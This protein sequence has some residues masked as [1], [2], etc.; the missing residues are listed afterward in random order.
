MTSGPRLRSGSAIVMVMV[1][2]AIVGVIAIV[3]SGQA[4]FVRRASVRSHYGFEAVEICE[5]AINEAHNQVVFEDIFPSPPFSNLQDWGVKIATND[6]NIGA[7]YP[8][9]T[10]NFRPLLDSTTKAPTGGQLF[11]SMLW[12]ADKRPTKANNYQGFLK[13]YNTPS[14]S[15][16]GAAMAGFKS[17]TPVKMSVLSW[18]RDFPEGGK[19]WQD[20]GV[21]HYET[22]C[23][24]DDG[25]SSITRTMS[26]D[27]MFTLYA[28]TI[29]LRPDTIDGVPV[30]PDPEAAE[31]DP[32]KIFFHFI[33]S[34]SNL[35][36]VII[37]S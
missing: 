35:K 18:R 31:T 25:K 33:K 28:H 3:T 17:L 7:G 10:F 14:T 1:F 5:S 29:A 11:V 8:G 19:A 22:A 26:V 13:I 36:T 2:L 16:N 12:P 32:L 6:T 15:A 20:W 24:F 4:S 21:L 37:R 9:Y 30:S 23:T 34:R 27:R